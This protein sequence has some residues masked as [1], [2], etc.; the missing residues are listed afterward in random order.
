VNTDKINNVKTNAIVTE[1]TPTLVRY[2][3]FREPNGKIYSVPKNDIE[4]IMYQDGRIEI[5]NLALSILGLISYF[6]MFNFSI[7]I[8]A[9]FTFS[10]LN[11]PLFINN[12]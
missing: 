2:K 4:S 5:I 8:N 11:M 6:S 9:F 10:F 3:L 1:I 12:D 7:C